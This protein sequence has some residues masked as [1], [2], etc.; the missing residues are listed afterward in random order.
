MPAQANSNATSPIL[1]YFDTVSH[2]KLGAPALF[3]C[4]AYADDL[5]MVVWSRSYRDNCR[6]LTQL[7]KKLIDIFGKPADGDFEPIEISD[8]VEESIHQQPASGEEM[9]G[10]PEDWEE[11]DWNANELGV[12][13]GPEKYAIIHYRRYGPKPEPS[14]VP[15]IPDLKIISSISRLRWNDE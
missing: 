5:S 12:E 15:E 9:D 7:H 2:S 4:W 11:I 14:D 10:R 6:P 3:R 8:E 13:F 1:E